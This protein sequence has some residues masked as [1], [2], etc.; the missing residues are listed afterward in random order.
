MSPYED[1]NKIDK[2]LLKRLLKYYFISEPSKVEYFRGNEESD[3]YNYQDYCII[4]DDDIKI[5]CDFNS[6]SIEFHYKS[7]YKEYNNY[8]ENIWLPPLMRSFDHNYMNE[9]KE[10]LDGHR[11]LIKCLE[12]RLFSKVRDS[13]IDSLINEE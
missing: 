12:N 3:D 4:Y 11:K 7:K 9:L 10:Y 8:G 1:I 6:N 13:K 2:G 5:K